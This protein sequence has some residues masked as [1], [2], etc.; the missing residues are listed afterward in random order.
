MYRDCFAHLPSIERRRIGS[1]A[2]TDIRMHR[3]ERVEPWPQ[4]VQ[5]QIWLTA[6]P[7]LIERYSYYPAFI[8][9]LAN[10]VG[11][12]SDR[13]VIGAGIEEFIRTLTFLCCDPGDVVASTWPSCAMYELYPQIFGARHTRVNTPLDGDWNVDRICLQIP[14]DTRLF[15]LVN[16]SQPVDVCLDLDELRKVARHCRTLGILLA[17]DEAYYGFGAPTALPLVDEFDNV[18]ILRTFSKAFGAA[19]IRVGYA[20]GQPKVIKPLD[21]ARP[22]GEI[23]GPSMH[24]ASVLLDLYDPHIKQGIREVCAGRDWLTRTFNENGHNAWGH[25]SNFVLVN[26]R[27]D[28]IAKRVA[29]GLRERGFFVR[30]TNPPPFAHT[31]M[32]TCGSMPLMR[33]FYDAF[34]EAAGS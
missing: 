25:W 30:D 22:S 28:A 1:N 23:S 14:L 33:R 17:I 12:P 5:D 13:I 27:E 34:E 8:E 10:F 29:E 19:S 15:F 24:V 32:V 31:L 26:M 18:V 6:Q 7:G 20:I 9:K 21:G 3:G 16:P 4:F 11:V 2:P